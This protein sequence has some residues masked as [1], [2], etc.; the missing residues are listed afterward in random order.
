[1]S[2]AFTQKDAR[3]IL[4]KFKAAQARKSPEAS[5]AASLPEEVLE[6]IAPVRKNVPLLETILANRGPIGIVSVDEQT[7]NLG[8]SVL[9]AD[10][11]NSW[12]LI[13]TDGVRYDVERSGRVRLAQTHSQVRQLTTA[14]IPG[15][16][17]TGFAPTRLAQAVMQQISLPDKD[18]YSL[19]NMGDGKYRVDD[20]VVDN[21]KSV[22]QCS[23]CNKIEA[24][25]RLT[26]PK[27]TLLRCGR[28]N[29]AYYCNPTCQR[30]HWS[31][32]KAACSIKQPIQ[33][34]HGLFVFFFD[35]IDFY[36]CFQEA[37]KKRRKQQTKRWFSLM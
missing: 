26:Q 29:S 19:E 10:N 2:R 5:I 31:K 37:Q 30:E 9:N 13:D 4:A 21:H 33:A 23:Y 15:G 27:F 14:S 22:R 17:M 6:A 20:R 34:S 25:E 35:D 12:V 36:V 8:G 16:K 18:G 32:H 28:C 3:A 7:Y 24:E 1:M 11:E